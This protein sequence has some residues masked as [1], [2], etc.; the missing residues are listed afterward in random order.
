MK[1]KV[2][3]EAMGSISAQGILE[4]QRMVGENRGCIGLQRTDGGLRIWYGQI[5]IM[6]IVVIR[7]HVAA[8]PGDRGPL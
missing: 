4:W 5:I 7:D 6:V 8:G 1:R 3:D 2:V